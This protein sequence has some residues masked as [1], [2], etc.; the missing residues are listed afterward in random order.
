MLVGTSP[1]LTP[2]LSDLFS[3]LAQAWWK[4]LAFSEHIFH[5]ASASDEVSD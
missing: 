4:L 5:S 2:N 1:D 3:L